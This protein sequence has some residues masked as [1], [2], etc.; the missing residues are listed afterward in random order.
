M[1]IIRC[2]CPSCKHSFHELIRWG[3]LS[4]RIC[5]KC[6]RL[7]VDVERLDVMRDCPRMVLIPLRLS[8]GRSA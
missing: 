2:E 1:P 8:V 5:P 4:E 6:G 3:Q 7:R